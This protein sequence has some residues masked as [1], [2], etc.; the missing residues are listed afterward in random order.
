MPVIATEARLTNADEMSFESDDTLKHFPDPVAT[1]TNARTHE[2][3]RHDGD[4]TFKFDV[5]GFVD[6]SSSQLPA[7]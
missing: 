2:H 5:T 6:A 4:S 1:G 3:L 7:V